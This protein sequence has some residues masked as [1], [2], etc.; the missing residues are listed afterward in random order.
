MKKISLALIGAIVC[1]LTSCFGEIGEYHEYWYYATIESTPTS[2]SLR[3]YYTGDKFSKIENLQY[4][5]HL[6]T[7]KLEDAP[8]ALVKIGVDIDAAYNQK[9]SL[10]EAYKVE[11]SS[12]THEVPTAIQPLSSL[13]PVFES[14][15]YYPTVWVQKG[16]LNVC[17]NIPAQEAGQFYLTPEKVKNDTLIFRLDASYKEDA[18]VPS[19]KNLFYDLR[20]LRDTAN[21]DSDLRAK[22]REALNA[23]EQHRN[24]SMLIGIKYEEIE[25]NFNYLGKDTIRTKYHFGNYFKCNF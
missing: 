4:P 16:Y 6:G 12:I 24:D 18:S 8:I 17:P 20:T 2:V 15:N 14:F 5:E 11:I 7:F 22:M 25:Y 1:L 9:L 3:E 13:V 21:T 19:S 23:I 10:L